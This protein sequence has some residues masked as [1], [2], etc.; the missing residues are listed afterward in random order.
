MK[1][2]IGFAI[3]LTSFAVPAW[4]QDQGDRSG[5]A[6]ARVGGIFN[7]NAAVSGNE[8]NFSVGF[9]VGDHLG[10][11]SVTKK[12]SLDFAFDYVSVSKEEVFIDYIGVARVNKHGLYFSP[13]MGLDVIK[14][15][16]VNL[17]LNG[18][19]TLYG[20]V[21]TISLR[22]YYNQWQNVCR[23]YYFYN[24]CQTD[25]DLLGNYGLGLNY[26][27]SANHPIYMGISY[28]R[29]TNRKNHLAG[30]FGVVF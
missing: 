14:N 20:Q 22:G 29:F 2:V 5:K 3:L 30:T 13:S 6:E 25:W 11:G 24:S 17:Y 7:S 12:L 9:K 27:P 4:A 10:R 28:L 1:R 8:G 23:Y 26:F 19:F 15:R 16:R 21:Q 18:G